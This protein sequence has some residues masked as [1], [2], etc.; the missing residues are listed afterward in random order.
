[1]SPL[2]PSHKNVLRVRYGLFSLILLGVAGIVGLSVGDQTGLSP[3]YL[4]VAALIV[5]LV[6]TIVIPGRRYRAWAYRTSDDELHIQQG[7]WVRSRTIIPFGRVQHID[8]SQGPV[9]RHY[10]VA[11]LTL[12][13][14]GTRSAAVALPGLD[15]HQ[16]EQMRDG[17]RTKIRQDLA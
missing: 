5:A 3:W 8:V 6:A 4:Y 13:T 9:E 7:I 10:G 14:A 1:M 12:H 15:F 17:I 16:A 2:S 11:T